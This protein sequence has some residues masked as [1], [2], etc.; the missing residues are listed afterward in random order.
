V[1]DF[2]NQLNESQRAA[3]EC[4]NGASLVIAGAG[5]GKT[6]VLTYKIAHLLEKG[7]DARSIL[8][9]TFTNKAA[10]EMK[11][12]ITK[13]VG[14]EASRNLQMGTFHSIFSKIL[15]IESASLGYSTNYSIYDSSDS[16]SVIQAVIKSLSLDTQNY[17]PAIVQSCISMAKN[18]LITP[19]VYAASAEIIERDKAA[20]LSYIAEIYRLYN[21]RCKASDAMDFDDL[22]LNTNILFRDF[23]DVLAKYQRYIRYILVDEYQDTNF[24][25]YLIIKKLA[26]NHRNIC[27]VGDDAQSI[28]SFRG[29]KIENILNF[30]NDY[31][32]YQLFK[33]EQN[34]RST[35]NIVNAANSVIAKNSQQIP[36]N[37]FSKNAEG[38]LVNV[39]SNATD[40]EEAYSIANEINTLK[41][42]DKVNLDEIAILYRTNAQSRVFE[43]AFRK[44]GIAYKIYGGLSFYQRK[45]IKDLTSYFRL[46]IN[47]NDNE[48]F[49]R[50]IN[51]PA[52][53]IGDTTLEKLETSANEN[54]TSLWNVINSEML[55]S[56][57]FNKGTLAKLEG[58]VKLIK[59]FAEMVGN[60]DAYNLARHIAVASGYLNA[61][62]EENTQESLNRIE[63]IDELLNS[64]QKFID[65]NAEENQIVTLNQF[66][67]TISLLTDA[68]NEDE[69]SREKVTLMTIHASKGLEFNYVF[70][71]GIE[72]DLF[73]SKRMVG[74]PAEL[75]EER[76]LFY[77]AIT[78][79]A[80]KATLSYSNFRYKHGSPTFCVPSRFIRDVDE[81]FL[82]TSRARDLYDT[83]K[84]TTDG[85]P[86]DPRTKAYS[87]DLRSVAEPKSTSTA[88]N[89][90]RRTLTRI[91]EVNR[92]PVAIPE[93]FEPDDPNSIKEGMTVLHQKFGPG[94]V[95]SIEG[96][97]PNN[98]ATVVF[99]MD[100]EKT[101]LLK[102]ARLKILN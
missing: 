17:K 86:V 18:N 76:R 95:V 71:V 93:N 33:L 16:K 90:V 99:E 20:K 66:M 53:G 28:Y 56:I 9:L 87:R 81:K 72:E 21:A 84:A 101:L 34:Y 3:V 44:M 23:P 64:I 48:A 91:Q 57:N 79:A 5:S 100:G 97:A 98:K 15:R 89:E 45:E 75:E 39:I 88:V 94:M 52:R 12:R 83:P 82:D 41:R 6:R 27:V 55:G 96:S 69:T 102:F 51:E 43:D 19:A 73:P 78:R 68:D 92:K 65:D 59:G 67:E 22:L 37:V 40:I 32:E 14:E 63:N 38:E 54:Q 35:Q 8:A 46:V 2:L 58:F 11:E 74:S 77:V 85:M 61:L 70:V 31:P 47:P 36:K 42:E 24:A 4:T 29:A 80:V 49:K 10:R 25:Q 26:A 1:S 30:K 62:K 50:C 60:T 13:L 7:I